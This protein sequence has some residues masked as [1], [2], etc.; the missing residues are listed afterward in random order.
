[1]QV[2]PNQILKQMKPTKQSTSIDPNFL[3]TQQLSY[4]IRNGKNKQNFPFKYVCTLNIF[5][6]KMLQLNH[7]C[8]FN[9]ESLEKELE[10]GH[11]MK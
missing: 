9:F 4:T 3:I 2:Y 6:F 1:M 11:S 7:K 10:V 5:L 8:R